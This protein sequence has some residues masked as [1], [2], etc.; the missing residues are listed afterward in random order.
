GLTKNGEVFTGRIACFDQTELPR[1]FPRLNRL[2]AGN[3][4]TDI[5]KLLDVHEAGD[6]VPAGEPRVDSSFVL[7]HA[8]MIVQNGGSDPTHCHHFVARWILSSPFLQGAREAVI[9]S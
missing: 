9:L 6:V 2:L 3:G 4:G 5:G 8:R 7:V 1:P